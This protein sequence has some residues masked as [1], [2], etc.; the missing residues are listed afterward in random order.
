MKWVSDL[1]K[2]FQK[3]GAHSICI[4]DMAGIASPE[5]MRCWVRELKDSVPDL[6]VIIHSHYTTGFSPITYIQAIE[7][8]ASG[9]D[10]GISTLSG[11]SG[12]PA[13]E[14]FNQ[15]LHDMGYDLGLHCEVRIF[16]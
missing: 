3:L 2:E 16:A 6:P 11:R 8:G 12:H 10:C 4:K 1:A 13:T 15:T 5:L 14:V 7:A 9:I